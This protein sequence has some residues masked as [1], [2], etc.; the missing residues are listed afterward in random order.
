MVEYFIKY[1]FDNET[2]LEFQGKAFQ[3]IAKAKE[4]KIK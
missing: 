3:V 2:R 1:H 4:Y